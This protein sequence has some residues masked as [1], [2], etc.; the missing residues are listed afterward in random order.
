MQTSSCASDHSENDGL[1]TRPAKQQRVDRDSESE[2]ISEVIQRVV[3]Q[4]LQSFQNQVAAMIS[5]QL[6]EQAKEIR[7][8]RKEIEKLRK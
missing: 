6:Q 3:K 2:D 1:D 8:L 4:E 5:E 7:A